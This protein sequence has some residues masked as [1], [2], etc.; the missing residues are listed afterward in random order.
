[1][2]SGI[3]IFNLIFNLIYNLVINFIYNLIIK[4]KAAKTQLEIRE[5]QFLRKSIGWQV[6]E[7]AEEHFQKWPNRTELIWRS[8]A[9]KVTP[10]RMFL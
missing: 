10:K 4:I 2:Q 3:L 9:I 5:K 6:N 7:Y 8:R 1:M